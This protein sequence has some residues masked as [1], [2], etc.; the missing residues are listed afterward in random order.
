[1]DVRDESGGVLP[2]LGLGHKFAYG[3][4]A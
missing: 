3:E 4:R 2:E 1:L